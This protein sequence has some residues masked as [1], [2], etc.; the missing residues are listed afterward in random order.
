M[1][2]PNRFSPTVPRVAAAAA[3]F[4]L[5]AGMLF[6]TKFKV[7]HP[8]PRSAYAEPDPEDSRNADDTGADADGGADGPDAQAPSGREDGTRNAP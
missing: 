6:W 8:M 4:V 1:R 3:T 2:R 5:F 7:I